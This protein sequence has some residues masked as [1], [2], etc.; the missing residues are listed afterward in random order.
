MEAKMSCVVQKK[1]RQAT[2]S[3]AVRVRVRIRVRVTF[4]GGDN[5]NKTQGSCKLVEVAPLRGAR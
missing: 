1:E 4:A 2:Q 3:I 5:F